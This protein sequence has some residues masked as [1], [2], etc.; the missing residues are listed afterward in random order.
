MSRIVLPPG[1]RPLYLIRGLSDPSDRVEE[2]AKLLEW[3]LACHMGNHDPIEAPVFLGTHV[4]RHA[5]KFASVVDVKRAVDICNRIKHTILDGTVPDTTQVKWAAECLDEA[6]VEVLRHVPKT[7][8]KV[9]DP[10]PVF[11][12][13]SRWQSLGSESVGGASGVSIASVLLYLHMHRMMAHP[14]RGAGRAQV[15]GAIG[16]FLLPSVENPLRFLRFDHGKLVFSRAKFAND[17][18]PIRL[19]AG[20]KPLI[21]IRKQRSPVDRV[22]DY[23]K[24]LEWLLVSFVSDPAVKQDLSEHVE[25][26]ANLFGSL[27]RVYFGLGVYNDLKHAVSSRATRTSAEIERAALNLE[28]AVVEV[29]PY[30]PWSVQRAVALEGIWARIRRI[31]LWCG[32][33]IIAL[34][35]LVGVGQLLRTAPSSG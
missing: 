31:A 8:R 12:A 1:K 28:W 25:S 7:V 21:L 29:L 17:V 18:S 4:Q 5:D 14:T 27:P 35:A 34:F 30:T 10:T 6:I 19:P 26:N 3:L 11:P 33:V 23:A 9:V 22:E 16:F 24:V 32:V 20:K 2:Y 15:L 13:L